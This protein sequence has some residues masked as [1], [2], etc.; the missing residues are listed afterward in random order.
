M[1]R[2]CA[3]SAS[4]NLKMNDKIAVRDTRVQH[5]LSRTGSDARNLPMK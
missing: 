1:T 3:E 4:E 5:P 2:R